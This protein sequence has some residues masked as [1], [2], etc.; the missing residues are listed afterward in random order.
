MSKPVTLSGV[1]PSGQPTLGNYLGAFLPFNKFQKDYD[2]FFMV[3][4]HHAITVRQKPQELHE[5]TYGIAAWYLASGLN[6]NLCKFFVQSHVPA[7]VE[8]GWILNTF[9][10]VGELERMTQYKDKARKEGSD[11]ANAGLFGY[12]V[13]M[14]ADILLYNSQKVPVGDDQT[15]HIEIARDIATRFN[16]I[17]GP[18]FTIPAIAKPEA[19]Q[20]VKDL[21][22]PTKKMSKSEAS[23]GT[24]MLLD[25]PAEAAKKISRAVTD[26]LGVITYDPKNQPG[27][28]NLIEILAATSNRTPQQ[29]V[30]EFEGQQYGP[31]KKAVAEAVAFTLEPLQAEYNRLMK[32]K[33]ELESILR[34]GAHKANEVATETL[35]RVKN[36]VG[37]VTL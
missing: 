7:H 23:A 1:K 8:L 27:L 25:T 36:A 12:P 4:D 37:Y 16:N 13:L 6:P 3:A 18:V 21:Q 31:L 28:A 19:A 14:A 15:Q 9:T 32:D 34:K 22:D 10:Q 20:R 26:S 5:N 30:Q 11:A 2:V 33:G 35:Q 24:I 29:V 17:Y